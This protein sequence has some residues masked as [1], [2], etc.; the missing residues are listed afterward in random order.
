MQ[1]IYAFHKEGGRE[2]DHVKIKKITACQSMYSFFRE[3]RLNLK[4]KFQVQVSSLL[5]K[6]EKIQ[7]MI[8]HCSQLAIAIRGE[9]WLDTK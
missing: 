1:L 5:R 8:Y 6:I 4:N 3:R 9:Q 2:N 7:N